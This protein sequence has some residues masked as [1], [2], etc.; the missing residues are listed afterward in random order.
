MSL[1]LPLIYLDK[2]DAA[3]LQLKEFGNSL[4]PVDE[5]RLDGSFKSCSNSSTPRLPTTTEN[6]KVGYQANKEAA[7]RGDAS[8]RT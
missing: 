5:P 1:A 6:L 3:F 4:K 8:K 2:S 7:R